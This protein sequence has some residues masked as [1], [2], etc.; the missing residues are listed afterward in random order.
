MVEIVNWVLLI[1]WVR[2]ELEIVNLCLSVFDG[3][4]GKLFGG[5]DGSEKLDW[6]VFR[7][8]CGLLLFIFNVI[9][10]LLGSLCVI[11]Y[12]V[13]VGVVNRFL[14]LF[15]VLVIFRILILRLV[16][17]KFML[18]GFVEIRILDRIGIVFC[19]LIMV[20]M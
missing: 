20:C 14:L 3:M 13:C 7:E 4:I 2:L 5:R 9:L 10:V 18:F 15:V 16:V 8:M 17:V 12:K 19:F 1:R 11:L 6:F